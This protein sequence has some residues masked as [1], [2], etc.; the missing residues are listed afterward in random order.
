MNLTEYQWKAF[1][2]ALYP[3]ILR[4]PAYPALGLCGE[5]GEVANKIKKLQRDGLSVDEVR[6]GVA[7][8]MGDVLWYL[9]A[10]AEELG[11]SLAEVAEQNLIKLSKRRAQNAIQGSGDWR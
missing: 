8:E 5:A 3:D 4:N 9:A 1:D 6:D 10:L 11:L 2:F 7:S